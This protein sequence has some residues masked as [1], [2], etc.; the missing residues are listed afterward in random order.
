MAELVWKHGLSATEAKD[1]VVKRIAEM[2]VDG[3]AQWEGAKVTARLA[4]GGVLDLAAEV[5]DDVVVLER[6]SGALG[7]RVAV[8]CRDI[9]ESEFPGGEVGTEVL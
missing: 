2:G 3:F 6:C 9:L 1:A 7:S 8:K 5:R 4:F